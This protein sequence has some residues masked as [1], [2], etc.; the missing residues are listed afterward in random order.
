MFEA[1]RY[2]LVDCL[3]RRIWSDASIERWY[4]QNLLL[5]VKEAVLH[6]N[7]RLRQEYA[8]SQDQILSI[9]HPETF[10]PMSFPQ[11]VKSVPGSLRRGFQRVMRNRTGRP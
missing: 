4:R 6:Q 7:D 5:Y 1:R 11:L 10:F 9:V 2:S 3:R 8:R